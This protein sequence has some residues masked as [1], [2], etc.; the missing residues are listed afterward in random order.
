MPPRAPRSSAWLLAWVWCATIAYA[1]LF[2]F[3]GW[4]WPAG[5]GARELLSLPWPRYFIGFD[6]TSNLLGYLPLGLLVALVRLR[7][8]AGT[9]AAVGAGVVAGAA[10]SYGLEVAQQLLPPRVPSL[11]DWLL[12]AGGAALGAMLAALL[13]FTGL[14]HLWVAVRAR[15]LDQG[16]GGAMALLLLWPAAL[17][18]PTPVPL[19]LG[20]VLVP[21]AAWLGEGLVDVPWAEPVADALAVLQQPSTVPV[22]PLALQLALGLGLAGPCLLAFAAARRGWRRVV[23][24]VGALAVAVGATTL[25]TALNFGPDHALAWLTGDAV[26]VLG[27]TAALAA[28]LMLVGQRVAAGLALM[29][30]TGLVVLVNQAPADPY[31]A[32]SLQG[33]EQGRFIRFHGMAQWLGWLWPFA[34]IG[35]LLARLGQPAAGGG[36]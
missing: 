28:G 32:Q 22:G 11:L 25:S 7:H 13:R 20:Q 21:L 1:S 12:N 9:W 3:A 31:F 5:L 36:A 19:G 26:V 16:Q 18:F 35:W 15:W 6:I 24:V 29:A 10:L 8:G 4:R 17:L 34:A 14:L 33:W 30:L 23:M 27:V 2:P